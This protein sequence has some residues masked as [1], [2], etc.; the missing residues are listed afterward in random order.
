[1]YAP[2]VD[3]RRVSGLQ[4]ARKELHSQ[5][6]SR[7]L[8]LS[9]LPCCKQFLIVQIRQELSFNFS[10]VCTVFLCCCSH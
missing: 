5:Y 8:T 4:Q 9:R 3:I 1:M 10:L 2:E 7:T 6:L